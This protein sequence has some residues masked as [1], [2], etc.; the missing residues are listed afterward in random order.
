MT[1]FK[2]LFS[3]CALLALAACG[4][5]GGDPGT[6]AFGPGAGT[7][8]GGGGG[9][10]TPIPPPT[11]I[12]ADLVLV[13]SSDTVSNTGTDTVTATVTALDGNRN[14]LRDVAI[15]VTADSDAIV[16]VTGAGA[17]I[18]D[19]AGTITATISIGANRT[20]RTIVVTARSGTLT[21]VANLAVVSSTQP[22]PT[23][24]DIT[25]ALSAASIAN[26]GS[27]T[28][29]ATVTAVDSNRNAIAGI[30]VTLRVNN[31]A[32]IIVSGTSTNAS[33][34]VTGT[35]GI[36]A[37]RANRPILITATSGTG[38][39]TLTR[40]SVLA[41]I[42]TRITATALPAV[43]VP[44][45]VGKVQYRV[46]DSN[47]SALSSFPIAVT[48]PGGVVTTAETDINGSYEFIYTAPTA[49]G[50]VVIR[51]V[52]GGIENLTTVIVQ[53]GTGVIP[54]VP[55]GSVRS[56]SVSANPSVVSVNTTS[57]T[58]NRA[59]IRALFVGN[60]NRPIQNIRVRFDLDGDTNS[61]GGS[62]AS[63]ST[64][65]Y[66]DANGV[67]PTAY[68]PGQRFSPTDGLTVRACWD[69]RDFAANLCPNAVRTTLTVI[70]DALSVSIGTDNLVVVSEDLVYSQ[71]FV[72]QVNDSSGLAKADVG[73]SP[74]LDLTS[75]SR[76]FYTRSTDTW[77]RT[78][79]AADCGNEDVNRNGVL[80]VYS[81]GNAEDANSNNQLEPRKADVVV[82]FEGSQRTD[83]TGRV[84]MR[85]TYP[86]NVGSWVRFSLTV[87]ATGV[88]GTEGR[89]SFAGPLI[90]PVEVIRAEASPPFQ[91]SPYGIT[92]GD[93][94]VVVT[95]PDGRSSASLC[96]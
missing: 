22:V 41:V 80:E 56:P 51:A 73:V 89:A 91:V 87:A 84:T 34:L 74:L 8:P 9:G 18:T 29:T 39:G 86:R 85:I 55:F 57:A 17:G 78:V 75:F 69:Y 76:G 28:V 21:K 62:L 15:A 46:T 7:G 96:R 59:E 60:E 1:T 58:G 10:T 35:I 11:V 45:E 16:T 92:L 65:V 43:L 83:A 54:E 5:G 12:A 50:S 24:A 27:A 49:A 63:G 67:A 53:A 95:T 81:N 90:V 94:R 6:P 48:G 70:S 88:A 42:G 20:N 47:N 4:G 82:S 71:R 36:G 30:P 13:L 52:S 25:L 61:I 23:A 37:N 33:G 26:S 93:P 40:T 79:T 77:L 3:I 68:I 14:A 32:T 66:S 38:A 72:V 44:A 2:R 19:A 31:D 64:I